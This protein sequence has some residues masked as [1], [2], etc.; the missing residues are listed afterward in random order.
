[1]SASLKKRLS[2]SEKAEK[3]IKAFKEEL[4][5]KREEMGEEEYNNKLLECIGKVK[6]KYKRN[7]KGKIKKLE[8]FQCEMFDKTKLENPN[9]TNDEIMEMLAPMIKQKKD[10]L[11]K[12]PRKHNRARNK[13]NVKKLDLRR[14]EFKKQ[15]KEKY[16]DISEE[17]MDER[18]EEYVKFESR[19]L[20]DDILFNKKIAEA[21]KKLESKYGTDPDSLMKI[22]GMM[23]EKLVKEKKKFLGIVEVPFEKRD[24]KSEE[25]P[26][27]GKR[28]QKERDQKE[29]DQKDEAHGKSLLGKGTQK[30]E[31]EAKPCRREGERE[32][33]RILAMKNND[34][35][36]KAIDAIDKIDTLF[37]EK[38][39]TAK[40]NVILDTDSN[41]I[42]IQKYEKELHEKLNSKTLLKERYGLIN[43]ELQQVSAEIKKEMQFNRKVSDEEESIRAEW[44][45]LKKYQN[46]PGALE[47]DVEKHMKRRRKI[48][49]EYAHMGVDPDEHDKTSL[50]K[51]NEIW[52]DV[53]QTIRDNRER[54]ND[55][56][57][58]QK[59][60]P[61]IDKYSDF[62]TG[63]QLIMK[64]MIFK[65]QYN[66]KAFKRFLEVCRKN[67]PPPSAKQSEIQNIR[68]ENQSRYAQYL[69]EE[70][71]KSKNQHIDN[72]TSQ[73]I[74][75]ETLKSLR[76]E[77][78]EFEKKYEEV[79]EKLDHEK[80]D[81]G[82]EVISQL[83][84]KIKS[85][86]SL[87][88]DEEDDAIELLNII[89]KMQQEQQDSIDNAVKD[90]IKG[91]TKIP[92]F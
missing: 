32:R 59:L 89:L 90:G 15:L 31:C 19:I 77:K 80:I 13:S 50:D 35:I 62:S 22:K 68:F 84:T 64:Y 41:E 55:M 17:Q 45:E 39:E 26:L 42:L 36:N 27:L 86:C 66:P 75:D 25:K 73:R 6:H 38:P 65:L 4:D 57:E 58:K 33:E 21:K 76:K 54:W 92:D 52:A 40:P 37:P 28:T 23:I 8:E 3:E 30:R 20:E 47:R 10:E 81:E 46:N 60:D 51:A 61:F 24:P 18:I 49:E 67:L 16:P 91:Y 43:S 34:K 44:S 79:K 5:A 2:R 71:Q 56:T 87:D 69:Y 14:I 12:I 85:G 72:K 83:V 53:Q 88:A 82:R 1:M 7:R 74:F 29:R 78:R 48:L 70:Y 63:Y 9:S 11:S